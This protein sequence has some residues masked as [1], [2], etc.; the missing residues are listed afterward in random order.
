MHVWSLALLAVTADGRAVWRGRGRDCCR[1]SAGWSHGFFAC[2]FISHLRSLPAGIAKVEWDNGWAMVR[3]SGRSPAEAWQGVIFV[4][5]KALFHF[6][7]FRWLGL[8]ILGLNGR[9]CLLTQCGP[10]AL[11]VNAFRE[12]VHT[13]PLNL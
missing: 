11:S 7:C 3:L 9:Q 6:H 10:K 4:L 12:G 8:W 5:C 1:S 13:Y 2:R